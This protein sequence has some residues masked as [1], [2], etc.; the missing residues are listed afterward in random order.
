M[1][2]DFGAL[3]ESPRLLIEA[4]LQPVQGSRFQPTGVSEPRARRVRLSGWGDAS[5][6]LKAR[7][8]WLIAWKRFAGTKGLM[9]G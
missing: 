3:S 8:V 1:N 9:T 7:R 5:C 2:L 6:W 4:D